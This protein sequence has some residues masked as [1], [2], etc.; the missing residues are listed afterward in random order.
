M[1]KLIELYYEYSDFNSDFIGEIIR[2]IDN[3][4]SD[5]YWVVSDID[6][7]ENDRDDYVNN[8]PLFSEN[9]VKFQEKVEREFGV[10]VSTEEFLDI[11]FNSRTIY[12]GAI[13]CF[14]NNIPKLRQYIPFTEG[15]IDKIKST[16]ALLEIRIID[17]DLIF[18]IGNEGENLDFVKEKFNKY[19]SRI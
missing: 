4:I 7:I 11:L 16:H 17:G 9:V 6:I 1:I 12:R 14:K 19:L 15:N 13:A 10:Y 5:I 3:F 18:L 8:K 2:Y